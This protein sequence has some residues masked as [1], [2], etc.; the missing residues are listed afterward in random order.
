M[1]LYMPFVTILTFCVLC[2]ITNFVRVLSKKTLHF[3][4]HLIQLRYAL[5]RTERAG[6]LLLGFSDNRPGNNF[7]PNFSALITYIILRSLNSSPRQWKIGR[8]NSSQ[9]GVEFLVNRDEQKEKGDVFGPNQRPGS[10]WEVRCA[11]IS[12]WKSPIFQW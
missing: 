8:L 1:P 6:D 5:E 9:S 12:N 4:L 2:I 10:N 7:I 3:A 11:L